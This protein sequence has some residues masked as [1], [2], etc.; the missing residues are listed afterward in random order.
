M[1]PDP[2]TGRRDDPSGGALTGIGPA[3]LPLP[4]PTPPTPRWINGRAFPA[5]W[6]ELLAFSRGGLVA[7]AKQFPQMRPGRPWQYRPDPDTGADIDQAIAAKLY[8]A[9]RALPLLAEAEV[10]LI[11]PPLADL[12]PD[13]GEDE[14][15]ARYVA[16]AQLPQSP[17]FLD[18]EGTD[19]LPAAWHVETWPLPLHLRGALCWQTEGMLCVMP[20]GS[21]GHVNPWG[22]TDY[23]TWA[24][25]IFLQEEPAQW[26]TPGPGDFLARANGEVLS[27]VDPETD[28]I[29][30]HHGALAYNLCSRTLR[31]LQLLEHLGGELVEPRLKRPLRRRAAR[32]G[33]QIARVPEHFPTVVAEQPPEASLGA[34]DDAATCVVPK[35]HAR[36]EQ[37]HALWH[38]ALAAYHDPELFV[39]KLNALIQA[40]RTVTWVL[41]KEF[42]NSKEF[43][44]WYEAWQDTMAADERLRWALAVR[45]EVE[46]QGD[47]ETSSVAHVR[48][49]APGLS[50]PV[51]DLDE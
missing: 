9:L 12:I 49:V 14:A 47:L 34:A 26:P 43:K 16:A 13:W 3:W 21:V 30:A 36:L 44:S 42:G 33:Q 46:H 45:N 38:E 40:L 51:S 39:T 50:A 15:E 41:Q 8:L 17:L 5:V 48:V 18:F 11:E 19:G 4:V 25:W 24:R 7:A 1:D 27:W 20:F 37:A 31:V 2:Q 32:E 22:G 6:R 10:A 28:S 23:H 35:T 29:C